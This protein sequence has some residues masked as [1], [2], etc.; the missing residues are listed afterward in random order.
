MNFFENLRQKKKHRH[1]GVGAS[2]TLLRIPVF[3]I[4][5]GLGIYLRAVADDLKVQ[6][7]A[8]RAAGIADFANLLTTGDTLSLADVNG[9]QV[10]VDGDETIGMANLHQIAVAA[11]QP[12]WA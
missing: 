5:I 10:S 2:G 9:I 4:E 8:F 7:R 11:V 1:N 12:V 3:G 6:V